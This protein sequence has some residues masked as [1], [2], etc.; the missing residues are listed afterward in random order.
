M[1]LKQLT[2]KEDASRILDFF[3][4]GKAFYW[5]LQENQK[6][7]IKERINNALNGEN[8]CRY[9][10]AEDDQSKIIAA[11]AI[12]EDVE[13]EGGF[14]VGWLGVD[15]DH[16]KQGLGK[17]IIQ[18]GEEYVKSLSGRFITIDTA[19]DNTAANA[20]YSSLG[21]QRVGLVPYYYGTNDGKVTY[22]KKI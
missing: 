17:R 21:Y 7:S 20:F 13:S 1:E 3:F 18:A 12:E 14:F 2:N 10:F 19:E 15:E 8:H 9:W 16:R 5:E 22:Y 11:G 6:D 4:S